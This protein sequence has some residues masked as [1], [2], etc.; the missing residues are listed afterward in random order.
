MNTSLKHQQIAIYYN[1]H[2]LSTVCYGSGVMT[3]N[4][5]EENE[6]RRLYETPTL[7]KLGFSSNFPRDM[8][9]ASQDMLRLGLVLPTT[10]IE[11]QGLRM[12]FGNKRLNR[13]L[14]G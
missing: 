5:K 11:I 1:L 8:M 10:M 6:L 14:L 7:N 4:E 12:C 3:L 2:M 9:C 13:T